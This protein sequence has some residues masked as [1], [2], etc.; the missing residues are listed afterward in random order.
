M[1]IK[2]YNVHNMFEHHF[3]VLLPTNYHKNLFFQKKVTVP[4]DAAFIGVP[5]DADISSPVCLDERILL[6]SANLDVIIQI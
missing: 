5:V 2:H 3:H 1:H 4:D 6:D